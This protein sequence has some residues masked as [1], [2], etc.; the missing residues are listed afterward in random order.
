MDVFKLDDGSCGVLPPVTSS[1]SSPDSGVKLGAEIFDNDFS[2]SFYDPIKKEYDEKPCIYDPNTVPDAVYTAKEYGP[3]PP[4]P[5]TESQALITPL[6]RNPMN[7]SPPAL[8][9][10]PPLVTSNAMQTGSATARTNGQTPVTLLYETKREIAESSS[11]PHKTG[12]S[13]NK[14]SNNSISQGT[15]DYVLI[16]WWWDSHHDYHYADEPY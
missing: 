12:K 5:G 1:T 14:N 8:A 15:S 2:L 16:L 4:Y 6:N 13:R 10:S 9:T 11:P 7:G 3:L